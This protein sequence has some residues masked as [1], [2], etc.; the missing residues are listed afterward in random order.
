[1][2]DARRNRQGVPAPAIPRAV[3]TRCL[4]V[5]EQTRFH[6]K[7]Y[8]TGRAVFGGGIDRLPRPMFLQRPGWLMLAGLLVAPAAVW[9]GRAVARRARIAIQIR[10]PLRNTAVEVQ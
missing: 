2:I 4:D 9:L 5:L 3:S 8:S 6:R 7:L 10:L 1:M